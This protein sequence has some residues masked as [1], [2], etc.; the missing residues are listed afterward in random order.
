M[1]QDIS[2]DC[3]HDAITSPRA[4]MHRE[5][6]PRWTPPPQTPRLSEEHI[7]IWRIDLTAASREPYR[8]PAPPGVNSFG[9]L[10]RAHAH[11][12]MHE[13]LAGYLDCPASE[14]QF[15][16]RPGGKPYL[17]TAGQPLEFN[18]SHSRDTALLAVTTG[19]AVGIDVETY[20]EI[21]D[22]LRLAH[23]VMSTEDCAELASLQDLERLE[24]FLLLWTRME[25]R[26]KAIGRGIFAQPADPALMSNFSFRPGLR[27]WA[28]L[29]VSPAVT[30]CELRFID[31]SPL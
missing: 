18:L 23:R 30:G 9:G 6:F 2:E 14:L 22:P 17:N 3:Y 27:R 13:I 31:F 5:V 16:V 26:Q 11:K 8:G 21:D 28:S 12:A 4:P 24:L 1:A 19:A 20:R 25:A 10:P 7:D 29:S 15:G